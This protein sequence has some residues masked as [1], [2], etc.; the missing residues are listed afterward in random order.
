MFGSAVLWEWLC[1]LAT[2][3]SFT[4]YLHPHPPLACHFIE[5]IWRSSFAIAGGRWSCDAVRSEVA[6]GLASKAE[7][8]KA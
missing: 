7:A 2:G 3:F 5:P 8:A 1:I 4:A 6:L